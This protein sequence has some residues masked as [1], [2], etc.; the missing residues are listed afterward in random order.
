MNYENYGGTPLLGINSSV[1]IGHGISNDIAIKN[2]LLLSKEVH[3][4]ELS[5]KIQE[6]LQKVSL[7]KPE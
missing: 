1:I 5:R 4:V 7:N 2:M 3:E 6:A